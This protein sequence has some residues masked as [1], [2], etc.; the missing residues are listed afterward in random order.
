MGPLATHSQ[1]QGESVPLLTMYDETCLVVGV[2]ASPESLAAVAWALRLADDLRCR[3]I[4][5]HAVGLLEGQHLRPHPDV[6]ATVAAARALDA[7]S[8][9][10]VETVIEDGMP[11]EIITRIAADHNAVLIVVGSRGLGRA[12][13]L[14]G[15][16]SEAVL[17]R[18]TIPVLIVP[19]G[20][21]PAAS[22][23]NDR[24]T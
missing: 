14:L 2:D 21:S 23:D 6:A 13:H 19:A 8:G 17:A 20:S 11:A 9:V 3:V 12:T 18:A 15:S 10:E 22:V 4:A 5:A 24:D 1:G 16:T 7:G